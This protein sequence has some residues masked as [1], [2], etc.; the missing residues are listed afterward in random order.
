MRNALPKMAPNQPPVQQQEA[1]HRVPFAKI[2]LPDPALRGS[3]FVDGRV[4]KN[5]T[6]THPLSKLVWDL[7]TLG[8]A[9]AAAGF[10]AWHAIRSLLKCMRVVAEACRAEFQK[11]L[12]QGGTKFPFPQS[13]RTCILKTQNTHPKQVPRNTESPALFPAQ[14]CLTMG[15]KNGAWDQ[16]IHIGPR[17]RGSQRELCNLIVGSH[18]V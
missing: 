15:D 6:H 11:N 2:G 4:V 1:L 5:H 7:A 8:L 16:S 9:L 12:S 18:V 13:H 17:Q 3:M 14:A 10:R